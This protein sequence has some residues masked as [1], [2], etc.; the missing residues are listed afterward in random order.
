MLKKRKQLR[1]KDYDYAQEGA[2]FVTM[3]TRDRKIHFEEN[4]SLMGFIR[5]QWVELP[6]AFPNIYLDEF[7]IMPNHIHG[8]IFI[9]CRGLI[10]QILNVPKG[11]MNH[12]PTE[13]WGL[14][15]NSNVTLGKIIRHFK[16]KCTKLI[17]N[18]GYT[19]FQWQRGYYDRIIR[20]DID[21]NKIRQYINN[22][23]IKWD[24][25]RNNPINLLV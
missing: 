1:L 21:L 12:A 14:M 4:S 3:C 19:E 20:N 23:P 13:Q 17:R 24:L 18:Q 16:A 5:T 7:I 10:Y 15:C 9:E 25:D 8:I 22:N 2:Y 6:E 11:V